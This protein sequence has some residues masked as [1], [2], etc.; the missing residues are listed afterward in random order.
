MLTP[1]GSFNGAQALQHNDIYF[2]SSDVITT[3]GMFFS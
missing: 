3:G 2:R 1:S